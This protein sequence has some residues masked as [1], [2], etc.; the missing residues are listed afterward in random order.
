MNERIHVQT[1]T[2]SMST[3]KASAEAQKKPDAGMLATG[4]KHYQPRKP[5]EKQKHATGGEPKQLFQS[6]DCH[7]TCLRRRLTAGSA[8]SAGKIRRD[9]LVNNPQIQGN[10]RA[11]RCD[12]P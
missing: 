3:L 9:A 10:A 6:G 2:Q 1:Y 12:L 11:K 7:E 5:R 8:A 4:E